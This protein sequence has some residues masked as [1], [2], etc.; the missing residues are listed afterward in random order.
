MKCLMCEGEFKEGEDHSCKDE[1]YGKYGYD[2]FDDIW[3]EWAMG[4][5]MKIDERLD[6]L[7]EQVL[8]KEREIEKLEDCKFLLLKDMQNSGGRSR[9][10]KK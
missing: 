9:G 6:L 8:S 5:L 1:L 4:R 10:G 7:K 3:A 2:R